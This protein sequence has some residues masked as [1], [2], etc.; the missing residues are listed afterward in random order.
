MFKNLCIDSMLVLS[1]AGA[2]LLKAP[3]SLLPGAGHWLGRI[4]IIDVLEVVQTD[5]III[6]SGQLQA[7][8]VAGQV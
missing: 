8:W 4:H 6:Q 5:H 1:T 2:W 3:N 7:A